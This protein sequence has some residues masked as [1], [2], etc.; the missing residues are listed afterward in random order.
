[1]ISAYIVGLWLF[2]KDSPLILR[3]TARSRPSCGLAF[4]GGV[5]AGLNAL[6]L[7][8]ERVGRDFKASHRHCKLRR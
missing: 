2:L 5:T 4:M 7:G 1:M 8:T 6:L 3:F